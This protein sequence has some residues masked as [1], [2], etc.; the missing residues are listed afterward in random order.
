LEKQVCLLKESLG[1]HYFNIVDK[2]SS[3]KQTLGA[4]TPKRAPKK[5]CHVPVMLCLFVAS[6]LFLFD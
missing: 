6:A 4:K 2:L 5:C 1:F 3:T